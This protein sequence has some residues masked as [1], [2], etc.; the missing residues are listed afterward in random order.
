LGGEGSAGAEEECGEERG[1]KYGEESRIVTQYRFQVAASRDTLSGISED[2]VVFSKTKK[3][4][5]TVIAGM[6]FGMVLASAQE[7]KKKEAKDQA[8]ADLINGL[9]KQTDPAKTLKDLEKWTHDYPDTAFAEERQNAY[10]RTYAQMSD[11]K[12]ASKV[13]REILAKKADDDLSLRIIIGC[14]YAIKGADATEYDSAEKAA[15]YV[16]DHPT[17]AADNQMSAADW[18]NFV[19]VTAK[20][21]PPFIDMQKKDDAKAESDMKRILGADPTDA[22]LSYWLAGVLFGQREKKPENQPPA[23]FEYARA[24]LY[25]GP[26]AVDAAT[27][28][29][30]A[31]R[32]TRYYK[33]YHGSDEGWDKV[34]SLAKTNAL[35]PADFSIKSTAD[36]AAEAAAA[37][38]AADAADPVFAIWKTIKTGLTGDGDAAFFDSSVK[39]SG[40]PSADGAKKFKGKLVSQSPALN[41]KKLVISYKDPAGDIT[42]V[43]ETPLRGK[44][45]PGAELEFFGEAQAYTKSPFNLTLKIADPK[46]DLIGW[47]SLPI[48]PPVTKK[49]GAAAT[50]KKAE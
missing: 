8:E 44:M 9:A 50:K 30:A 45:D 23:I 14:I 18:D 41:P 38:A 16:V 7:P 26:H 3:I 24:G 35:P 46:T 21:V 34:A 29:D 39:G 47:K 10:L 43:L 2:R 17:K 37:E 19:N 1:K 33:A 42:L 22:Q 6:A 20:N 12:N 40:L 31:T 36:L 48:A 15:Q 13:A 4:A 28:K 32:A 5:L 25:E 49:S 11:C 27:K